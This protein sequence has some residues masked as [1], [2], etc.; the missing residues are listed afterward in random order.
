[1]RSDTQTQ[2]LKE[3]DSRKLDI[4]TLQEIRY[5]GQ[6]QMSFGKYFL[7]Y[8]GHDGAYNPKESQA[9]QGPLELRGGQ[10]AKG[11]AT[12]SVEKRNL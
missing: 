6:G 11:L 7:Y 10:A 12:F 5:S 8:V 4:L 3:N 9:L 2:L 1:M